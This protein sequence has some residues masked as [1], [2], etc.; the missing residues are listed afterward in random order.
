M[1]PTAQRHAVW[2]VRSDGLGS[3]RGVGAGL[4]DQHFTGDG[5]QVVGNRSQGAPLTIAASD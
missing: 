5:E 2:E 1:Q 3:E 4:I